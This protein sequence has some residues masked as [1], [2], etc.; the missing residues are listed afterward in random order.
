MLP[1]TGD[2][3]PSRSSALLS[4]VHVLE[5]VRHL[6]YGLL[7]LSIVALLG[8]SG[9]LTVC[10]LLDE[11]RTARTSGAIVNAGGEQLGRTADLRLLNRI[12]L[13]LRLL[14]LLL[15]RQ[16][17]LGVLAVATCSSIT[18]HLSHLSG[19]VLPPAGFVNGLGS[20]LGLGMGLSLRC[21]LC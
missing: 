15:L 18:V 21:G 9:L 7:T 2:R 20:W 16:V 11:L 14:M 17:G 4:H 5:L 19:R 12:A 1:V 3:L 13:T 6:V 8:I 10:R